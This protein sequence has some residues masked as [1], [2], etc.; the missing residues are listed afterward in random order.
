[1][2]SAISVNS[3]RNVVTE[4]IGFDSHLYEWLESPAD[5]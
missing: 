4:F 1:L 3:Y 5:P 2:A